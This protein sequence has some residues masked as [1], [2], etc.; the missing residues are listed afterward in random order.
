MPYIAIAIDVISVSLSVIFVKL[1]SAESAII[2][3]YPMLF[4]VLIMSLVFLLKYK[5]ELK[6]L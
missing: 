2:A 6:L 5:S 4:F 3:F 1:C